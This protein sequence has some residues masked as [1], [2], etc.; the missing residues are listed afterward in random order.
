MIRGRAQ[1]FG[2]DIN[3]DYIIAAQHKAASLDIG[4][5]AQHTFADIDAEFV[6][7]AR[8]GDI[9]VADRNFGCGSSRETAVHVLIELGI[10]AVLAP[11]FARI[12]FRNAIN[13]G[14][15]VFECDTSAINQ[16]DDIEVYLQ[17]GFA[18]DHTRDLRLHIT[19]LP[20]I[21]QAVLSAGG[22]VAYL[23]EHGDLVLPPDPDSAP[24][25]LR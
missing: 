3:T 11:S 19:P 2:A 18:F 4:T 13:S 24:G 9:V 21:M 14:L 23:A 20:P 10:G 15:P 25:D 8:P 7:R 16:N 5:M 6:E 1:R 17:R 22:I 12:Y